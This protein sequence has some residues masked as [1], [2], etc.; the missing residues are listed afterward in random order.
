MK[1]VRSIFIILIFIIISFPE[2]ENEYE[3]SHLYFDINTMDILDEIGTYKGFYWESDGCGYIT[4]IDFN[5]DSTFTITA[6]METMPSKQILS[7]GKWTQERNNTNI[8]VK[9]KDSNKRIKYSFDNGFITM[10]GGCAM[11]F[12]RKK[13]IID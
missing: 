1:V 3:K 8:Y 6:I 5:S 9:Y 2:I 12:K 4:E 11:I 7:T 13:R 10:T